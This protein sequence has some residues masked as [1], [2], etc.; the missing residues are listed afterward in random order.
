MDVF[1]PNHEIQP[2]ATEGQ[3][4]VE[5]IRSNTGAERN[6]ITVDAVGLFRVFEEHWNIFVDEPEH[7]YWSVGGPT[8]ITDNLE[9]ARRYALLGFTD[10][11]SDEVD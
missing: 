4:I 3:R 1:P 11:T 9:T 2:T 5:M 7:A 8:H 10:S 6:Y